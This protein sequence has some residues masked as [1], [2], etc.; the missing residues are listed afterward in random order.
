M[1]GSSLRRY[2]ER[3]LAARSQHTYL[4]VRRMTNTS[5]LLRLV[6]DE[7]TFLL[8]SPEGKIVSYCDRAKTPYV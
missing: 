5:S 6:D 4:V 7:Q 2:V 1:P 3:A 8:F